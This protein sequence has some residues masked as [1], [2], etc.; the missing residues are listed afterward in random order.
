MHEGCKNPLGGQA[1]P[2]ALTAKISFLDWH[3][4]TEKQIIYTYNEDATDKGVLC[5]RDISHGQHCSA[6]L[7]V[8]MRTYQ[9]NIWPINGRMDNFIL[10]GGTLCDLARLSR[11]FPCIDWEGRLKKLCISQSFWSCKSK[12]FW[13]CSR[14]PCR[15]RQQQA[16]QRR[17]INETIGRHSFCFWIIFDTAVDE[18]GEGVFNC[19]YKTFMLGPTG[20]YKQFEQYAWYLTYKIFRFGII[21]EIKILLKLVE[22]ALGSMPQNP[23]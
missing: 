16:I 8:N 19:V 9:R 3:V 5:G 6:F 15:T 18:I 12:P 23:F 14:C 2:N 13:C 17:K 10:N 20:A 21:V 7:A 1:W 4:D 22:T 11:H